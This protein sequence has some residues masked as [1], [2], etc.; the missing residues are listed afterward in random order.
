MQKKK[1]PRS[2]IKRTEA[3]KKSKND[4]ENRLIIPDKIGD[5]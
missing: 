5:Q 4:D 1:P 3:R 2:N